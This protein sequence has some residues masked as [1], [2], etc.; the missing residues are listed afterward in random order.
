MIARALLRRVALFVP[1]LV[2]SS[3]LVF[4][5][6][7]I[8]TP[9]PSTTALSVGSTPA[10]REAFIRERHLDRPLPEQYFRW[11]GGAVQGDFGRSLITTEPVATAIRQSLPVTFQ[12]ALGSLLVTMVF[13]L[14]LGSVAG[15]RRGG[16]L[17]HVVGA[18]SV[19]GVS[20]PTFV[21]GI[22]LIEFL[23]VRTS[24]FPAGGY[25]SPGESPWKFAESM[26]LPWIT[27]SVAPICF[28][29]RVTRARVADEVQRP[30][31]RTALALGV[32]RR[33][34]RL[35]YVLRNSTV[36]PTA[37]L[38][39]QL[40]FMLGGVVLVEQVFGLPGLGSVALFAANQGDFPVLQA[41]ALLA[42]VIFTATSLLVDVLHILLDRGVA[43]H[44]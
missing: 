42:M 2:G 4:A 32:G 44:G 16:V 41:T 5:A 39:I 10:A 29:A 11:A 7:R 17:D 24:Y 35:L 22:L 15:L 26:A 9:N 18:L 31:V 33:R 37:V 38:G 30:H 25:V 14:T 12:L 40:G 19:V 34:A 28:V 3:I 1:V 27:L 21:L 36:E 43:R 23:A 6:G 20:V 8:A 13:G